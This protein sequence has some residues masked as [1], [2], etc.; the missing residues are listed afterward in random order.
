[1]Q[2]VMHGRP[3][4]VPSMINLSP[5]FHDDDHEHDDD[6]ALLMINPYLPLRLYIRCSTVGYCSKYIDRLI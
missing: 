1:M 3:D 2:Q 5:K 4:G 6:I